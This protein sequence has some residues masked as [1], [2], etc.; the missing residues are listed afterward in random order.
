[1]DFFFS[2]VWLFAPDIKAVFRR[3]RLRK[4]YFI[5]CGKTNSSS[6]YALM[7]KDCILSQMK[8]KSVQQSET[9]KTQGAA[10]HKIQTLFESKS[11]ICGNHVGCRLT[12][13][14]EAFPPV[15]RWVLGYSRP[16]SLLDLQGSLRLSPSISSQPGSPICSCGRCPPL[17]HLCAP[18]FSFVPG[19]GMYSI[20]HAYYQQSQSLF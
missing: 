9:I 5:G 16:P 3:I 6:D 18:R 15:N 19:S 20:R 4:K 14:L 17:C 8:V 10:V 12:W 2:S 1:M 11:W 7:N 13:L